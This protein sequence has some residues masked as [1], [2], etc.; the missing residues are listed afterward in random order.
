MIIRLS[1]SEGEDA[2]TSGERQR[3]AAVGEMPARDREFE[4]LLRNAAEVQKADIGCKLRGEA[5]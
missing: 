4:A 5:L 2:N 3:M 1:E